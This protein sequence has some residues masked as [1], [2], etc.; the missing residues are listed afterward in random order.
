MTGPSASQS[1]RT[2]IVQMVSHVPSSF[3]AETFGRQGLC[4][5]SP[6]CHAG[7][8]CDVIRHD[9]HRYALCELHR[10][11]SRLL[12]RHP[13]GGVSQCR[14]CNPD[15]Q[16]SSAPSV[17]AGRAAIGTQDDSTTRAWS[18]GG[19]G[20]ERGLLPPGVRVVPWPRS[21][22]HLAVG[23]SG[24]GQD[25]VEAEPTVLEDPDELG[26]APADGLGT[27]ATPTGPQEP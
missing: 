14:R 24:A 16:P 20:K 13:P 12:H 9:G 15:R 26:D 2:Y 8:V 10:A 19:G 4:S 27:P 3:S 6:D 17:R 1:G 23:I 7:A 11:T 18:G 5:F 21:P 22:V 25:G